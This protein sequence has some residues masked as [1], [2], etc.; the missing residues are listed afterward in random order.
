MHLTETCT[1]EGDNNISLLNHYDILA[2]ICKDG[3]EMSD[4]SIH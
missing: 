1:G 2:G 4:L 3:K